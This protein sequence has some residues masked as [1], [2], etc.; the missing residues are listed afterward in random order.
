MGIKSFLTL[1]LALKFHYLPNLLFFS[2]T[3]V[4]VHV[5]VGDIGHADKGGT[6]G[7]ECDSKKKDAR[8]G[9]VLD[10]VNIEQP[11]RSRMRPN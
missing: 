9:H 2:S 4:D 7:N 1:L 10:L 11:H 5:P 3:A 8:N 6:F